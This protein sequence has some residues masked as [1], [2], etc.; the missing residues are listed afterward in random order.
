[1]KCKICKNDSNNKI[2][3]AK[4]MMFGF[5]D[6]FDYLEC[7]KCGCVQLINIPLNM[8][9]Y[10]PTDYYSLKKGKQQILNQIKNR[11]KL[12]KEI[13]GITRKGIIG[14]LL[15]NY[16]SGH[17]YYDIFKEIS[18]DSKILDVGCGK[19]ELLMALEKIG[20]ENLH[21]VDPFLEK[22][23]NNK[24]V[25]IKKSTVLEV[26][27][28]FDVIMLHNSF[29]HIEE[30]KETLEKINEILDNEGVC[31]IRI[32]IIS[33]H[34]WDKY[35][36]N[37]FQLD[38]PRHLFLHSIKSFK[39]LVEKCGLELRKTEFDSTRFQFVSSELYKKD[40][41]AVK[42]NYSKYFS[43]KQLSDYDKMARKLN[44]NK[45]GDHA[46]FYLSKKNA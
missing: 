24:G 21:G 39:L 5:R 23:I 46:I 34:I 22:S 3:N 26:D 36:T 37:W 45:D 11:L 40:I 9:K 15:F 13:Y 12:E 16:F 20:Y 19:G 2:H 41:P 38:A 33:K 42:H 14:K 44:I 18:Y 25:K 27:E 6:N 7:G 30:Q 8:S 28:K 1:M 31:I 43:K 35:G 10:Y 4:E 32:P 29:E 17:D